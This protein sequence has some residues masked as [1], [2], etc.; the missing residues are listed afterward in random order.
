MTLR[1]PLRKS[2]SAVA[3]AAFTAVG[4]LMASPAGPAWRMLS[5]RLRLPLATACPPGSWFCAETGAPPAPPP[6]PP[7]PPSGANGGA[8]SG[9]GVRLSTDPPRLLRPRLRAVQL[10]WGSPGAAGRYL[11]AR[12]ALHD[13]ERTSADV[14]VHAASAPE[15]GVGFEPALPGRPAREQVLG[16]VGAHGRWRRRPPLPSAPRPTRSK[17]TS[18]STVAAITTTSRAAR[19]RSRSTTTSS[20]TRTTA[21]R[22]TC[23]PVSAGRSPARK[24]TTLQLELRHLP[25]RLL[26]SVRRH[27]AEWRLSKH[28]ALNA[29]ARGFIRGRIDDNL[30][31]DPGVRERRR[32]QGEQHVGRRSLHGRHD[33]LF[34][35]RPTT[36]IA[37]HAVDGSS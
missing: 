28:F 3:F 15:A 14:P 21:S 13:A 12:S 19:R 7:P 24:T 11:P 8:G 25:L 30:H 33:L 26:R 9:P 23:W 17:P 4:A 36:S 20:S 2:A 16:H 37:P 18:I 5:N 34:L 22:S 29:D 1:A 31:D 35:T 6:P 32:Q 27:R 10:R